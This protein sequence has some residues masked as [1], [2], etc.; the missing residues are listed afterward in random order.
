MVE[1]DLFDAINENRLAIL[2]A[3]NIWKE[4]VAANSVRAASEPGYTLGM[5]LGCI[6]EI[7]Q[8]LPKTYS[9][10]KW[11]HGQDH[12]CRID[13]SGSQEFTNDVPERSSAAAFFQ[14]EGKAVAAILGECFRTGVFVRPSANRKRPLDDQ[15]EDLDNQP[16]KPSKETAKKVTHLRINLTEQSHR[17]LLAA[18]AGRMKWTVDWQ[19][20]KDEENEKTTATL[21]MDPNDGRAPWVVKGVGQADK[22]ARQAATIKFLEL[23]NRLGIIKPVSNLMLDPPPLDS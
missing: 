16:K 3:L 6:S 22:S 15:S 5:L 23:L 20:T 7:C 13:L 9:L 4:E 12:Y 14:A 10:I 17:G 8:D 2:P 18:L 11:T 19:M 21:T 1:R